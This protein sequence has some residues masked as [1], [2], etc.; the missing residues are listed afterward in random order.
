MRTL[1][2]HKIQQVVKALSTK[3][4]PLTLDEAKELVRGARRVQDI[5]FSWQKERHIREAKRYLREANRIIN[6]HGVEMGVVSKGG[7]GAIY[8]HVNVGDLD[9]PTVIW[10][11]GRV[12]IGCVAD[13]VEKYPSLL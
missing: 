11:E 13:I 1:T 2:Q 7:K 6:G 9:S 10:F 5:N 12:R 4:Y 8:L 3:A